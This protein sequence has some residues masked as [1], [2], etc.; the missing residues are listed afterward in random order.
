MENFSP[1]ELLS[2]IA[3]LEEKL[4]EADRVNQEQAAQAAGEP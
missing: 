2:K 1:Q 3:A 4:N